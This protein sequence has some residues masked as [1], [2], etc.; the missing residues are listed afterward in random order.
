MSEVLLNR[1]LAETFSYWATSLGIVVALAG[2]FWAYWKHRGDRQQHRWDEARR[3]YG[4]FIDIAIDHP[5]FYPG[6]WSDLAEQDPELTNSY[7]WLMA[8]FLWAAEDIV[9]HLNPSDEEGRKAWI[10]A[11]KVTICEHA[12]FFR[13]PAGLIERECYYEPLTLI[14]DQTL[15]DEC[16]PA[17]E[18]PTRAAPET[19]APPRPRRRKK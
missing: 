14:I 6:R 12:D 8:R 11:I 19:A 18:A 13:S 17:P 9:L 1:E 15:E 2:G 7:R 5:E 4:S 10:N 16:P 3:L